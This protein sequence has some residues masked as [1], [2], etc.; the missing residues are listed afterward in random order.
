MD[1]EQLGFDFAQLGFFLDLRR[2]LSDRTTLAAKWECRLQP[3]VKFDG[4][5]PYGEGRTA[6]EA[7][8][9]AKARIPGSMVA[10]D[11]EAQEYFANAARV[12]ER[13]VN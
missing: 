5:W 11:D 6:K 3:F 8:A 12:R 10:L 2:V 13:E 4:D 1:I 9:K 7:I